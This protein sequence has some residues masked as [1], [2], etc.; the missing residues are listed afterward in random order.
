MIK[1][2]DKRVVPEKMQQKILRIQEMEQYYDEVLHMVNSCPDAAAGDDAIRK[3]LQ[4]LEEYHAGGQW[5]DDYESD[6]RG[7]LPADLKRGV[8]SQ[9][10]LY[11][12]LCDIRNCRNLDHGSFIHK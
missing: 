3:K 1:E 12:L 7:E 4:M 8:L 10:G 2:A 6:E 5:L 11:N 9:D